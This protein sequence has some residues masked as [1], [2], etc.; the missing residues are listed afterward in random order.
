MQLFSA[1]TTVFS[2]KLKKNWSRKH[3]KNPLQ[4]LLI[5]SP[6]LFFIYGPKIEIPYHQNPL[7]AGLGI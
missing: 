2:K 1:D 3:E 6:Q 7:N 4:K 5:I